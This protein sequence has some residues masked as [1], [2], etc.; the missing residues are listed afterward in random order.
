MKSFKNF[1]TEDKPTLVDFYATWCGPCKVM[2]HILEEFKKMVGT[3]VRV[4]K[5]DIDAP[6][7][8]A[9]TR[10]YNISS[11]PTL[12]FFRKGEVKWRTSGIATAAELKDISDNL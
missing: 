6:A 11:V 3:D 10:E 7:N 9:L 2:H 1:I 12:M 8:A 5:L 4:L